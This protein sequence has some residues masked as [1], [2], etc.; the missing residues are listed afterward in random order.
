MLC[1]YLEHVVYQMYTHIER[2]CPRVNTVFFCL[3]V[4]GAYNT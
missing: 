3:I 4:S 1:M 2:Q